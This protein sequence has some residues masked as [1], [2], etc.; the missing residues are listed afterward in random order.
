M[1]RTVLRL[2]WRILRRDRAA[3][4]VLGIFAAFLVLA[5]IAGGRQASSLDAGLERSLTEER[6]RMAA[7]AEALA[8]ADPAAESNDE[9]PE[10]NKTKVA[11][12]EKAKGAA[13]DK[14]PVGPEPIYF[15]F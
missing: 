8:T 14:A 4:T 1:W 2:E 6:E 13:K 5:A 10:E 3:L 11:E 12:A 9:C 15:A 7:H